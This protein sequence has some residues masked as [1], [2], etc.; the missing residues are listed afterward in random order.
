ME[1]ANFRH[2]KTEQTFSNM[3]P[4]KNPSIIQQTLKFHLRIMKNLFTNYIVLIFRKRF[5]KVN[6]FRENVYNP[7][8]D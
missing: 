5:C 1:N 8:R 7:Y 4:K 3:N 6:E 2:S